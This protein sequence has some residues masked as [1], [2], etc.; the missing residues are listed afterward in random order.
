MAEKLQ[1]VIVGEDGFSGAFGKLQTALPS[2][3]TLAL[4]SAGAITGMGA[5]LI[6]I[7]KSTAEAQAEVGFFSTRIGITTEALSSYQSVARFANLE[8]ETLNDGFKELT[9]R[10]AEAKTGVGAGAEALEA[11]GIG[12]DEISDRSPDKQF[13]IFAKALD[14][15]ADSGEKVFLAE[16]LMGDAGSQLLQVLTN[17]SEGLAEMTQEA[18]RFGTVVSQNS[19]NN[20]ILFQNSL[21]RMQM[22]FEGLR[23]AVG[24]R[25]MPILTELNN[26]FADFVADNREPIMELAEKIGGALVSI[27][28]KGI[29]VGAAIGDVF[30]GIKV[31]ALLVETIILKWVQ[32][33]VKAWSDL[34]G[35][36]GDLLNFFKGPFVSVF[37]AVFTFVSDKVIE[38]IETFNFGG[39]F[40]GAIEGL[41]SFK[42]TAVDSISGTLDSLTSGIEG[43]SNTLGD[44]STFIGEF[45]D[46][47]A[48]QML[49][50][51]DEPSMLTKAEALI[52]TFKTA[53][54]EIVD[55]S[56]TTGE[57]ITDNLV[58][59]PKETATQLQANVDAQAAALEQITAM[60]DDYF[61]SEQEKSDQWYQDQQEALSGNHEG[62]VM[63]DD[64]YFTEKAQRQYD[65]NLAEID[66]ERAKNEQE[67]ADE[68][69]AREE[70]YENM[71]NIA[72]AVSLFSQGSAKKLAK[73]IQRIRIGE[74][75][76][77]T[78][79]GATAAYAAAGGFPFGVIPAAITM[80]SGLANV[81]AIK[82]VSVA[83]DGLTNVP[84]ETTFLLDKGERVIKTRQ[85]ED[86]TNFLANANNGGGT[87]G[88]GMTNNITIFPNATN[89]DAMLGL[90]ESTWL[91]I[92]EDKILPALSRLNRAGVTI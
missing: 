62:L 4:A 85:N 8:Q 25:F 61:L 37:D 9:N 52:S 7:T 53:F 90:S 23:N 21:T 41:Q 27:A 31:A 10:V 42:Q 77:E 50:L 39:I 30:R 86:L 84:R 67:T 17:G 20:A 92:T 78:Y 28:E 88:A 49:D 56:K 54:A 46:E 69:A 68:K 45:A 91:E 33:S 1:F 51:I 29:W 19:A 22:A 2:I 76:V 79:K 13:E 89:V 57:D 36:G 14:D 34:I 11:L 3:K 24:E 44:A 35:A 75:L 65:A 38:L 40:D 73:I 72:N 71:R 83:H 26:R 48:S 63:L 12:I 80:A 16:E 47:A 6:A 66:A 5:A 58:P 43:V 32:S 87:G 82:G 64:L 81:A 60:H 15:V 18:D 59:D 55:A 70:R 74:T